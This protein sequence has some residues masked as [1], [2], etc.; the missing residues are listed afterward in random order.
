MQRM[1][2]FINIVDINDTSNKNVNFIE[3]NYFDFV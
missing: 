1:M 2:T 3:I